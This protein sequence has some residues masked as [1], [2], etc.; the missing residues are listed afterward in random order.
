MS[1]T[2]RARNSHSPKTSNST[3]DRNLPK[4][5]LMNLI[6]TILRI[7]KCRKSSDSSNWKMPNLSC[8]KESRHIGSINSR[9][10][11]S[12]LLTY[13]GITAETK[14]EVKV[15]H[16]KMIL[17]LL[18]QLVSCQISQIYRT[19]ISSGNRPTLISVHSLK[20]KLVNHQNVSKALPKVKHHSKPQAKSQNKS[21]NSSSNKARIKALTQR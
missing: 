11:S 2:E 20:A 8:R 6:S 13:K 9:L 21:S 14:A 12:Q 10:R 1:I 7:T 15:K 3:S 18:G 4:V 5:K 16:W 19:Q 17:C